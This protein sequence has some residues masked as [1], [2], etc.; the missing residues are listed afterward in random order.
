MKACRKMKMKG[1][2]ANWFKSLENKVLENKTK[3]TIKKEFG[4]NKPNDLFILANLKNISNDKR[5]Q[6]WIL[7]KK[8]DEKEAKVGRIIK[9]IRHN[10][11]EIEH[12]EKTTE[13]DCKQTSISPC[14]GCRWSQEKENNKCILTKRFRR[15]KRSLDPSW[16]LRSHST[17]QPVYKIKVPWRNLTGEKDT[18]KRK[19]GTEEIEES[20]L[21][22]LQIKSLNEV[23]I[24]GTN[25]ENTI[26]Q[27]LKKIAENIQNE[28]T[29][30]IYT[31]GSLFN[32][33]EEGDKKLKMGIR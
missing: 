8:G 29:V 32:E 9:K 5:K 31:D 15:I 22:D 28:Y 27:D 33:E 12:Y 19:T 2:M 25:Q 23:L 6:E 1:K 13:D 26:A 10:L 3:R 18:E 21:E 17:E 14:T 16:I 20:P 30:N 4:S 11:F 7:F 24:E